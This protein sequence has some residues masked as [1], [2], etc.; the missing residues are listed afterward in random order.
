MNNATEN[1]SSEEQEYN[2]I[3]KS[4][5]KNI[6]WKV[7]EDGFVYCLTNCL[8]FPKKNTI[9]NN[10]KTPAKDPIFISSLKTNYLLFNQ[11]NMSQY[12]NFS[13]N[14]FTQ[15]NQ[16]ATIEEPGVKLSQIDLLPCSPF[17]IHT[18]YDFLK[19][20]TKREQ[21]NGLPEPDLISMFDKDPKIDLNIIRD[22]LIRVKNEVLL[23]FLLLYL[24]TSDIVKN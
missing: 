22:R 24:N 8:L 5:K 14:Y 12:G 4:N 1:L 18:N 9:Q 23:I 2:L 15:L 10:E 16:N 11:T 19:S 20:I 21:L 6:Y 3:F 17:T 13:Q 7:T